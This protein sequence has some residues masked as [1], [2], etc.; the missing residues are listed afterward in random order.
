LTGA[1]LL[2]NLVGEGTSIVLSAIQQSGVCGTQ[3]RR[4]RAGGVDLVPGGE[5]VFFSL[6]ATAFCPN[7]WARID[8]I[9]EWAIGAHDRA[10]IASLHYEGGREAELA[11][12][13]HE[14]LTK[15]GKSGDD[16]D[17]GV[18]LGK[19]G[20]RSQITGGFTQSDFLVLDLRMEINLLEELFHAG[21]GG[22]VVAR[23][24]R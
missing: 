19:T 22:G 2:N 5:V 7:G 20:V 23:F 4:G 16:G 14:V 9:F 11:L 10:D 3:K 12:K 24:E 18:D 15:F 1:N 21:A 17:S 8:K 13:I 6:F